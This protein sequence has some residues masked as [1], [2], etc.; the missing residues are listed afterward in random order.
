[1]CV[2][3]VCWIVVEVVGVGV[4]G[5]VW[6]VSVC[7]VWHMVYSGHCKVVCVWYG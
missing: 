4:C 1:M 6:S 5:V 2:C 3:G 7:G